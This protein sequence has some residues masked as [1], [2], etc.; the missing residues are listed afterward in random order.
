MVFLFNSIPK[1]LLAYILH[2]RKLIFACGRIT[3]PITIEKSKP[4]IATHFLHNLVKNGESQSKDYEKWDVQTLMHFL[5]GLE[6]SRNYVK[7][8]NARK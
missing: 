8:R 4:H 5:E 6:H 3:S 7:F 2:P 1:I